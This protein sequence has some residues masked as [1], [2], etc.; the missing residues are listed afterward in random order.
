MVIAGTSCVDFSGLNSHQKDLDDG[1]ESADTWNAVLSYCRVFRPAIVLLENVSGADW[2]RMLADYEKIE[3][4]CSGAMVNTRDY[5]IPQVRE[6][7]Y[8]AGFNKRSPGYVLGSA[9][10]WVD[11]MEQFKRPAS[12]PVSDF[13]ISN[14]KIV[15]KAIR[16]DEAT[17]D[18]DWKQCEITQMEY[19]QD[20]RLGWARPVT[21]WSESRWMLP[22]D[23]GHAAWYHKQVER[24]LHTIDGAVLR[25]ALN[26]YDYR[27]K[28]R[29]FDLSQ[30][31]YRET[32]HR[33]FGIAGCITP[34]GIY[35]VTDLGR[36]LTS[37]ETLKLQGLPLEKISFTTEQ[38]SEI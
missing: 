5:Y 35:F 8:M 37:E 36:V 11:L 19:R 3:Y 17:R 38:Q 13:L 26:M 22:P 32:D 15:Q 30:N 20:M 2:D 24:V 34:S 1:G 27:F 16:H 18:H 10:R 4:E 21:N 25:K 14:D 29:I 31:I 12:S 33:P 7:G 28:T 6:R 23:I 9:E